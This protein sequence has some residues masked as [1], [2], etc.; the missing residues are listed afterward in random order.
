VR[1]GVGLCEGKEGKRS[2]ERAF[3][4]LGL[5]VWQVQCRVNMASRLTHEGKSHSEKKLFASRN[6]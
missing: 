2:A 6:S 1:S 3:K 5:E 4:F